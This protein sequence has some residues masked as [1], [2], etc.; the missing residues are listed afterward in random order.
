M[1]IELLILILFFFVMYP[2]IKLGFIIGKLAACRAVRIINLHGN[3]I[4]S[5]IGILPNCKA[6]I[7]GHSLINSNF[8]KHSVIVCIVNFKRKFGT[9]RIQNHAGFYVIYGCRAV[10]S[11]IDGKVHHIGI[12]SIGSALSLSENKIIGMILIILIVCP[13]SLADPDLKILVSQL[14]KAALADLTQHYNRHLV[15]SF[16]QIVSYPS[17]QRHTFFPIQSSYTFRFLSVMKRTCYLKWEGVAI[18]HIFLCLVPD[19]S[20]SHIKSDINFFQLRTAFNG[21]GNG[22]IFPRL[23]SCNLI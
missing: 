7:Q 5:R 3:R 19:L 12:N 2:H 10:I 21:K 14:L 15:I 11:Q 23:P 16:C 22:H 6:V 20:S 17:A 18:L 13:G 4:I 1:F 9:V 8:F